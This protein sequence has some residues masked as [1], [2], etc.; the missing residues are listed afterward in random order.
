M[1]CLFGSKRYAESWFVLKFHISPLRFTLQFQATIASTL[2]I[3]SDEE[4]ASILQSATDC[5]E[6]ECSIDDVSELIAEL[7]E[8]EKEMQVRLEKKS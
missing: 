6:G 4:T 1:H 2:L 8:Q 5:A 3:L 7:K